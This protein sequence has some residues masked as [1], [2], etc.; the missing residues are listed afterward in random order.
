MTLLLMINPS[1]ISV[2]HP[3]A[4]PLTLHAEL[5]GLHMDPQQDVLLPQ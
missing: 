3:L 2:L 5:P 4:N 1:L